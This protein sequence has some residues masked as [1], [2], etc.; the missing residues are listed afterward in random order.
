MRTVKDVDV[1]EALEQLGGGFVSALGAAARRADEDNLR[2]IKQA[3]PEYWAR[4][5]ALAEKAKK[6]A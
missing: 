1:I 5:T 4:Y 6:G 3:W 2:R